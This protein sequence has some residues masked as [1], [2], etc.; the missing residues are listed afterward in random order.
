MHEFSI[1]CLKQI[2]LYKK[3]YTIIK[4]DLFQV[5]K[6]VLSN[7]SDCNSSHQLAKEEM[8]HDISINTEKSFDRIPDSLM[9][10]KW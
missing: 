1:K 7:I 3:L 8:S 6:F 9:T 10:K 4:W 5:F 2:Q